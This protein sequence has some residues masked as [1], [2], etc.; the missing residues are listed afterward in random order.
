MFTQKEQRATDAELKES[1]GDNR[2]LGSSK[3]TAA[4]LKERKALLLMK[5][6]GHISDRFS[7]SIRKITHACVLLLQEKRQLAHHP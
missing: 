1:S 6:R 7:R 5:Y 3:A 4:Y 2:G